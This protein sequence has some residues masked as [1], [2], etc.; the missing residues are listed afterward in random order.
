MAGPLV[1]LKLD[2]LRGAYRRESP[3]R[4]SALGA[5]VA[6]SIGMAAWFVVVSIVAFAAPGPYANLVTICCGT[7]AMIGAFV[8]GALARPANLIDP[9]ALVFAGVP[10]RRAAW[11]SLLS[12]FVSV[13]AACA[14]AAALASALIWAKDPIALLGALVLVVVGVPT[15]VLLSAAGSLVS[16]VLEARRTASDVRATALFGAVLLASPIAFA[17]ITAPWGTP[18]RSVMGET[19]AV[20]SYTPVGAVWALPDAL[21]TEG[22]VVFGIQLAIALSTLGALVWLWMSFATRLGESLLRDYGARHDVALGAFGTF[23][24]SAAGVIGVRTVT[25]WL[26]DPRYRA[27][28]VA[29]VLIPLLVLVPLAIVGVDPHRLAL[30]PVPVIAF[31][32]GFTLHNDMAFDGSAVWLHV[33]SP[34]AGVDDRMGRSMPALVFGLPVV[35]AGSAVS[36]L[37]A[38]DWLSALSVLGISTGLLLGAAG[39]SSIGSVL[40]PYPVARPEDSPFSQP[41][42]SWGTAVLWHPVFALIAIAAVA[43]AVVLAVIGIATG[44]WWWHVAALGAGVVAGL[45]VFSIGIRVGGRLF[46]QRSSE[47]MAFAVS[48]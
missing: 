14:A 42:R 30:I 29:T 28:N 1:Q 27:V 48:A 45:I 18:G 35:V 3:Y 6:S 5:V 31:F 24:R 47:I 20:L 36:G 15:L 37:L 22:I 23:G 39:M 26:R 4:R 41:V 13:P 33:T 46:E 43:P 11:Q 2:S 7:A 12:R 16:T 10:P 34:M 8:G 17:L 44:T 21:A 25:A 19:T 32:I 9:R 40:H 38:G